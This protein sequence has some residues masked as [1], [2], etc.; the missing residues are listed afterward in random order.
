VIIVPGPSGSSTPDVAG[1]MEGGSAPGSEASL[2]DG[3]PLDHG[4]VASDSGP[5]IDATADS[6]DENTDADDSGAFVADASSDTISGDAHSSIT[7][8]GHAVELGALGGL[9]PFGNAPLAFREIGILDATG[10]LFTTSTDSRG[11]FEAS[12]ITPPYDAVVYPGSSSDFPYVYFGLVTSRPRLVGDVTL[13]QYT[14]KVNTSIQFQNCGASSCQCSATDWLPDLSSYMSLGC[15]PI[16]SNQ[17][18]VSLNPNVAWAGAPSITADLQVLEFDPQAQHFWHGVAS[19]ISIM[20]NQT[21]TV[22]PLVMAPVPTAGTLTV[23]VTNEGVPTTWQQQEDLS[24]D[25]PSNDG[26]A[27]LV[28]NVAPPLVSGVPNIPGST[29]AAGISATDPNST[30]YTGSLTGARAHNLPLSTTSVALTL[31]PP[32]TV[33]SP[34]NNSSLSQASSIQWSSTS[35]QQLYQAIILPLAQTD[36]GPTLNAGPQAMVYTSG[37]SVDLSKLT[38]LG[39]TISPGLTFLELWSDGLVASLDAM[40]DEQTLAQADDTQWGIVFV[41]FTLTP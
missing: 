19:G 22:P 15:G 2:P 13:T 37:N 41:E 9:L 33:I 8:A 29:L 28:I 26:F 18:T 7:V 16:S 35:T 5:E 21:T 39:V 3:S 12:G 32:P 1:D 17:L 34:L 24:L 14:A 36:A 31:K 10:K 30:T 11:A 40:V 20:A 25:Y 27:E 6:R 23:S 4:S 38:S